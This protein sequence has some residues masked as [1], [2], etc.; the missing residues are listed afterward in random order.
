MTFYILSALTFVW[1]CFMTYLS[2]EDGIHTS[3]TSHNAAQTVTN[4]NEHIRITEK[5]TNA[6]DTFLRHWAHPTVFFVLTLLLLSTLKT[7][8]YKALPAIIFL[9]VWSFLDEYSKQLITGRHY[10][11]DDVKFNMA[12][13]VAGIAVFYAAVF[14]L[15]RGNKNERSQAE[16]S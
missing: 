15:N 9:F 1:F 11:F 13:V 7:R 2:H 3:V 8:N 10:S 14:I 6:I 4:V 12:G 16:S 5:N